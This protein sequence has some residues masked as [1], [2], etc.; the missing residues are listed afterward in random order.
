M[1]RLS[2]LFEKKVA[3]YFYLEF[4]ITKKNWCEQK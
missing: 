1:Q 4:K 2:R 3:R